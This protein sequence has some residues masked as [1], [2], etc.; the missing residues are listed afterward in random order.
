MTDSK[1]L[2]ISSVH[3]NR[4][5]RQLNRNFNRTKKLEKPGDIVSEFLDH[6]SDLYAPQMRFG[7]HPRSF[8][9]TKHK[10]DFIAPLEQLQTADAKSRKFKSFLE[11]KPKLEEPKKTTIEISRRFGE[12]RNLQQLYDSLKVFKRALA[13]C[14]FFRF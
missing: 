14:F 7:N 4:S 11:L 6:G 9:F 5:M 10:T 13:S 3:H 12:E 2:C 1:L 8:H